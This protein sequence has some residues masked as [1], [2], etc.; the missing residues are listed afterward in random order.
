MWTDFKAFLFVLKIYHNVLPFP[1]SWHP[2]NLSAFHSSDCKIKYCFYVISHGLDAHL[3]MLC[4][5]SPQVAAKCYQKGGAAEKSKL[6]L[7]HDAVLKVHAK[8]SSPRWG[9]QCSWVSVTLWS[10]GWDSHPAL[11]PDWGRW[12]AVQEGCLCVFVVGKRDLRN[13]KV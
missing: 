4:V 2:A 10:R 6:V 11:G 8:K 12:R 3:W 1:F 5:I 9:Y 13:W 7:T